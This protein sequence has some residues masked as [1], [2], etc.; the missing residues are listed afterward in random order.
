[1]STNGTHNVTDAEPSNPIEVT[2][3][4]THRVPDIEASNPIDE[5]RELLNGASVDERLEALLQTIRTWDSADV[6][7]GSGSTRDRS[8]STEV[9]RSSGRTFT[10]ARSG[11][12]DAHGSR[13]R[14][15]TPSGDVDGVTSYD[16]CSRARSRGTGATYPPVPG[17]E[18][19]G[20]TTGLGGT[21]S[22]RQV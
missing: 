2:T 9:H 18:H 12:I 19:R 11:G 6:S 13:C 17:P 5:S 3:N 21:A 10:S 14:C 15:F 22:S 8:G 7:R 4:G 20:H 1:M 16:A